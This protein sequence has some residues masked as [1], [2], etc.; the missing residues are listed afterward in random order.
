[1]MMLEFEWRPSVAAGLPGV[2]GLLASLCVSIDGIDRRFRWLG[3]W[4]F[5]YL[6]RPPLLKYHVIPKV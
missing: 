5:R 3:D 6:I 4:K 2:L 1:M